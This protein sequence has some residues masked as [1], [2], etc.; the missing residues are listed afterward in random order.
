MAKKVILTESELIKMI[1]QIVEENKASEM[2]E[3]SWLPGTKAYK[4][5]KALKKAL[6]SDD[7]SGEEKDEF[8]LDTDEKSEKKRTVQRFGERLNRRRHSRERTAQGL[9]K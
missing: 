1:Q 3:Q 2:G 8:A 6:K 9:P 5:K 4:R 7:D